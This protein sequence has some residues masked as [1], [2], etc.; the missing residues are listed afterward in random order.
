VT[1]FD[2]SGRTILV[3][4]GAGYLGLPCCTLMASLGANIAIADINPERLA[5]AKTAI[6]AAGRGEVLALELDIGDEASVL[7]S[8]EAAADRFGGLWGLVNATFGSTGKRFD[9]LTAAEFD[10]ANRL[11]L[12]GSFVLARA[13]ATHMAE[14]GSMVLYA[15]MYGVVAPNPANYPAGMAPNPIEYGAGKAGIVQMVRYMA[16]HFGPRN[17]RVNAVAP[18]PYPHQATQDGSAEFMANLSRSAML[19]RIGRQEEM[20]GPTAFLLGD[21]ASYITGQCLNV[22]GGWTA[23]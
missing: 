7:H 13:A 17:I 5:A 3:A 19:G 9:E 6:E 21:A 15:S 18:G 20:A 12:T 4:G 10:R 11:N 8:V 16:G 1:P 23:W 14:G 22:D 2:F